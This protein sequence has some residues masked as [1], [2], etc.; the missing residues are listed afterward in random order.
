MDPHLSAIDPR[1]RPL[2]TATL[3]KDPARR[4]GIQDLLIR[5]VRAAAPGSGLVDTAGTEGGGGED[6]LRA[7][8]EQAD[9]SPLY[10]ATLAVAPLG[11][12]AENAYAGLPAP[13]QRA[14]LELLLRLVVPG[15]AEDGSQSSVRTAHRSELFDGRPA[16]EQQAMALAVDGLTAAG[17]L[18]VEPD[19]GVRPV[20]TALLPAWSRLRGWAA[21]HRVSRTR[22]QRLAQATNRWHA[23]GRRGEDL[24][25]G[26]E[27]RTL[28]DWL[29]TVPAD[30][31]PKPAE[32]Q[33]LTAARTVRRRRQLLAGLAGVT[34]LPLL[35]GTVTYLQ[36]READARQAEAQ[37]CTVA[38]TA[39]NLRNAEPDTAMLLGLTSYR[40]APVPEALGAL[41][42]SLTQRTTETIALPSIE[43]GTDSGMAL[44]QSGSGLVVYSP[45]RTTLT[46]LTT[47]APAASRPSRTPRVLPGAYTWVEGSP[48]YVLRGPAIGPLASGSG[49]AV[50]PCRTDDLGGGVTGPEGCRRRR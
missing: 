2:L 4:P 31:R 28:L 42:G 7:G 3:A 5:L 30:L 9:R 23:H 8:A 22:L 26:S 45:T 19:G 47:P 10:T 21:H 50:S 27:P 1:L 12:R 35:A 43:N 16:S 33:F 15:G 24:L 11:E 48:R 49:M 32:L 14:T 39:Q 46:D 29:A 13:T 20:S 37:A 34:V 36:N 40:I 6:R 25:S 38:Q 17:A 18:V 44:T 41:Y